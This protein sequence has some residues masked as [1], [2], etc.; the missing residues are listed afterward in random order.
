M[1]R[2]ETLQKEEDQEG[3]T[4]PKESSSNSLFTLKKQL[5]LIE[6][7]GVIIGGVVGSG[8]F[9]SPMGVLQ[10][11]GSIGASLVVWAASGMLA[12]LGALSFAELG[13]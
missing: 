6:A 12:M 11:S 7:V 9:I 10:Y 5:G 2:E 3:K 4:H 1:Q 13:N 8:I